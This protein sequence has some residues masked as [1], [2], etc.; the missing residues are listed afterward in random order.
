MI[1]FWTLLL[2]SITLTAAPAARQPGQGIP[3][4]LFGMSGRNL[5]DP[6]TSGMQQARPETILKDLEMARARGA[7]M[8]V[9]FAGGGPKFTDGDGRFVFDMWKARLDRFRP[10]ADQ[11]NGY[12]ADGTLL[13]NLIVDEPSSKKRWGGE[14]IPAATLDQMAQYA[15]TIFPSLPT[16]IREAPSELRDH[17]WRSL[18]L[19]WAQYTVHKGPIAS[20]VT[21]EVDAARA[22]GLGLVVGLNISKGGDG[23]S[24][25]GDPKE[26]A[27]SGEEILR[28]G[29]AL[30]DTPSACAFISWDDRPEV[31][32]RPEVAAA[33]AELAEAAKAH[34]E[35]ACRRSDR[36]ERE[37]GRGSTP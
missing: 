27:M 21:A 34:A 26:P 15:K 32:H 35:T 4:G 20:Y 30:L 25:F 10:I 7:R 37:T 31:I 22:A 6:Y 19:A 18:D 1:R 29:R 24:G 12:V 11:I 5:V 8:V 33:L 14:V 36:P 13:A 17:Q 9:N 28:Y 16:A 2:S 3:F 23:T